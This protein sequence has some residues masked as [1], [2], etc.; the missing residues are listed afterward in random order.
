MAAGPDPA[1]NR[2]RRSRLLAEALSMPVEERVR[3]A[4]REL[5]AIRSTPALGGRGASRSR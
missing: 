4:L 2:G 1:A 3:S 5:A